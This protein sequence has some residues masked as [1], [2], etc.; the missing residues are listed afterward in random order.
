MRF[1]SLVDI[2]DGERVLLLRDLRQECNDQ[3]QIAKLAGQ[4][5]WIAFGDRVDDFVR[6]LSDFRREA[7]P[8]LGAVPRT[9]VRGA[10]ESDD[11]MQSL[12]A[13]PSLPNGQRSDRNV[14]PQVVIRTDVDVFEFTVDALEQCHDG[15]DVAFIQLPALVLLE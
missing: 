10:Q 12:S 8:I 11:L 4:L 14:E 3:E 1:T 15:R 2:L 7:C 13:A 9:A 6:F 5:A